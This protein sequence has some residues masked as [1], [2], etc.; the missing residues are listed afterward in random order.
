MKQRVDFVPVPLTPQRIRLATRVAASK[1]Q[2]E[3]NRKD[4]IVYFQVKDIK[5]LEEKLF[6]KIN[7]YQFARQMKNW[8]LIVPL[9]LELNFL[10]EEYAKAKLY[11]MLP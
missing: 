5:D 10:T 1:A 8:D 9:E 3:K 4:A 6:D 2:R 7:D 11:I